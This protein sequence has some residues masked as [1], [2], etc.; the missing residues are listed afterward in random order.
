MKKEFKSFQR[1]QLL[2]RKD[3]RENSNYLKFL[4]IEGIPKILDFI[5]DARLTN[6]YRRSTTLFTDEYYNEGYKFL[7]FNWVYTDQRIPDE[8]MIN[9][10]L[11]INE[12]FRLNNSIRSKLSE[13]KTDGSHKEWIFGVNMRDK[14]YWTEEQDER[15]NIGLISNPDLFNIEEKVIKRVMRHLPPLTV[16]QLNK[17]EFEVLNKKLMKLINEFKSEIKLKAK[18]LVPKEKIESINLIFRSKE[19]E[20]AKVRNSNNEI[21]Y[22]RE[23]IIGDLEG[24]EAIDSIEL[25]PEILSNQVYNIN[26]KVYYNISKLINKFRN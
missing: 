11:S 23:A 4:Q 18:S 26:L 8:F 2:I 7:E 17:K 9:S 5:P 15:L 10:N 6:F 3:L 1:R 24:N 21:V 19:F 25:I 20:Y 13:I 16:P 12:P 14:L 22:L